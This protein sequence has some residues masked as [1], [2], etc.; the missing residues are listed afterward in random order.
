LRPT[1][2]PQSIP[3]LNGI[4]GIAVLIVVLYHCKEKLA[5]TALNS[6]VQ[7]GWTGVDLFFVLSGF[8]ITGIILEGKSDRHFFRGFYWRRLLRIWPMYLLLLG[9][10][11]A[12]NSSWRPRASGVHWFYYLLLLQNLTLVPLPGPLV[13]TWSLAIEEQYY[14]LWAPLARWIRS[15][16]AMFAVLIALVVVSPLA[17][18]SH[19]GMLSTTNT[20]FHLDGIAFGSLTAYLLYTQSLTRRSW[21]RVAIAVT[22]M[23]TVATV[24]FAWGGSPFLDTAFALLFT[25]LLLAGVA[26]TG[27]STLHARL[28][29]FGFLTYLG[30]ISYGLYMTHMLVFIVIGS[31]DGRLARF[32]IAGGIAVI[33][34]RLAISTAVA[35]ALWYGFESPILKLKRLYPKRPAKPQTSDKFIPVE[36]GAGFSGGA[37]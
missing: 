19:V 32:G 34:I 33:L 22:T 5:G 14:L 3:E 10:A 12:L 21:R 16:S 35:T 4:R 6:A 9:V 36:A 17:R 27:E 20:L 28:M 1:W 18:M 26:W 37:V 15:R 29:R 7:W 23:G 31:V 30:K 24:Y 8:L 25:G 13:P 11:F 2:L